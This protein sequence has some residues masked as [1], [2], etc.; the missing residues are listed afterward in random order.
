MYV[1]TIG[2]SWLNVAISIQ[3]GRPSS[4]QSWVQAYKFFL[5]WELQEKTTA[6]NEIIFSFFEA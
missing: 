2:P 5:N 1:F 6:Q 3:S 4:Y